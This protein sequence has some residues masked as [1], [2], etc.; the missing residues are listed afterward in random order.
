MVEKQ[1]VQP[2]TTSKPFGVWTPA[3]V[4]APGRLMFISG[5]TSRDSDGEVFGVGD[6]RAQT[7]QVLENLRA[8]LEAAGGDLGDVVS[9]TVHI[10]DMNDFDAIHQVRREYFPVTPPA[11]TMVEVSRMVDERSLIEITAIA[12]LP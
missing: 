7:R 12:V 9:V 2:D 10:A 11:S 8:T 4:V 1:Y 6:I 3:V 5:I